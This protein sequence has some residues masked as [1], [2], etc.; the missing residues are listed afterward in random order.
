[1]AYGRGGNQGVRPMRKKAERFEDLE[2]WQKAHAVVL[3][4]YRTTKSFPNDE[5]FG[6]ISQMRRA[7]VSMAA[8]PMLPTTDSLQRLC[9]R[10][11][12]G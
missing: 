3:E 10:K 8:P 9:G 4:T 6:F 1:M 7:A 11:A 2:V 5:R 12:N